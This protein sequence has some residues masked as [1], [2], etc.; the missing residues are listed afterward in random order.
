MD[1]TISCVGGKA[2]ACKH[3]LRSPTLVR[4]LTAVRHAQLTWIEM[5]A[6]TYQRFGPPSVVEVSDIPKPEPG[7]GEVLLRVHASGVN[8]GDWRIRSAAFP[9]IL[10]IPGRLMFGVMKPR[11]QRLGTEFAGVVEDVGSGVSRFAQ[12][13]RVYGFSASAGASADYLVISETAAISVLPDSVSFTEGAALPFGGLAALVF[14]TQFGELQADQHVLIVGAS[15]GVGV[16]A[17]QIA[18]AYGAQVTG[19]AGPASQ[20]LTKELGADQTIDYTITNP[21]KLTGRFDLIVD[22]VGALS[23]RDALS[24]LKPDGLFLPLNM[25][26]REIGAALLNGVR[27]KKVRLRVNEDTAEDMATLTELVQKGTVKPVIDST[28]PLEDAAEAHAR[29]EGRH[30]KGAVVLTHT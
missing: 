22:T 13:D 9:G 25:G 30:K 29:V 4:T 12:G 24:L 23:P 26:M 3:R 27:S 19:I 21:A 5:R 14:L 6:L 18:K 8:S 10:A 17:V 11:R 7:G 28:Y 20:K 15:G 2:F 1:G 16:Y